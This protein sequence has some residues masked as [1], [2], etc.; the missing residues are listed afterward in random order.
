MIFYD[1]R[2][3]GYMV[4][5]NGTF[6][7]S[8]ADNA[9]FFLGPGLSYGRYQKKIS[10]YYEEWKRSIGVECDDDV[11]YEVSANGNKVYVHETIRISS[12]RIFNLVYDYEEKCVWVELQPDIWAPCFCRDFA[13]FVRKNMNKL[14]EETYDHAIGIIDNIK[15]L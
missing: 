15:K 2:R 1:R 10:E 3:V 9:Q 6:S 8:D 12:C 13:I 4:L 14:Y 7:W 5:R 11:M